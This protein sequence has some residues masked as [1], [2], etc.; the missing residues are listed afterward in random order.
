[1]NFSEH[2]PIADKFLVDVDWGEFDANQDS[3]LQKG[4]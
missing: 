3:I 2:S 4:Y 1:M